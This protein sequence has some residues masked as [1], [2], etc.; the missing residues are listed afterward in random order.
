V[1]GKKK[2]NPATSSKTRK[3]I[4]GQPND[5]VGRGDNNMANELGYSA[6]KIIK[7]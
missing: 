7:I 5:Y 2:D 6:L 1:K 3:L 4:S